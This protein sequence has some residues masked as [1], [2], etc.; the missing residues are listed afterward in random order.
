MD[1]DLLLALLDQ[2]DAAHGDG[3][4]VV[5][6]IGKV[7]CRHARGDVVDFWPFAGWLS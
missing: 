5:A 3:Q 4:A 1:L 7:V 6:Q 2:V